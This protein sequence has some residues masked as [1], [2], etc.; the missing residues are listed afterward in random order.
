LNRDQPSIAGSGKLDSIRDEIGDDLAEAHVIDLDGSME[1]ATELDPQLDVF[2]PGFGGEY[3]YD[4]VE[5]LAIGVGPLMARETS[6][7]AYLDPKINV[8]VTKVESVELYTG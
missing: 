4:L 7:L 6:H 5:C 3:R 1:M 2:H 8:D